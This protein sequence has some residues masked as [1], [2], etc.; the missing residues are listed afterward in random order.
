[1]QSFSDAP[2][3]SCCTSS[4][5]QQQQY[6]FVFGYGS[7]I[8][9]DSRAKTAQSLAKRDGLPVVISSL[10]RVWSG[11]M[12]GSTAMGVRFKQGAE[13]TGVLVEVT[14][15]ELAGLDKRESNYVRLQVHLDKVDKVPFLP[16]TDF[17]ETQQSKGLFNAKEAQGDT[18]KVW[19][20]I[21]EK[22]KPAESSHPIPQS[23]LDIILSGC[24]DISEE[25]ARSCIDTTAGWSNEQEV[26]FVDDREHP[27]YIRADRELSAENAEVID[28]L[29]GEHI[30]KAFQNR[31]KFNPETHRK[32]HPRPVKRKKRVPD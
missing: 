14:K 9:A 21:P 3:A 24:L 4:S 13:C 19:V 12:R 6:Q 18:V 20:Y 32:A 10:Q 11:R 8:N 1:M 2:A 22:P 30:P 28:Q 17:Y 16:E 15:E 27:I 29:L 23:Y 25:F 26:C 7:L 31:V 5:P